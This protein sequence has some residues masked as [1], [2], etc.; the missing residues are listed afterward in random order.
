MKTIVLVNRRITVR[1]VAE[2]LNISIGSCHSIFIN[3]L[4]MTRAAAWPRNSYQNCSILTKNS[5]ADS[6]RGHP[7]LLQRLI[8]G[9]ESWVCGYDVQI[10][11][12]SFQSKLPHE[13]RSKKALQIRSNLTVFLTVFFVC[14]VV[15]RQF[16]PQGRMVKLCANCSK[17]S[18]RNARICGRTKIGF[19]TMITPLLTHRCLCAT[20]SAS[21]IGKT[22]AQ[23][24]NIWWGLL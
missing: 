5:I 2:D 22:L 18:A 10:K 15:V 21:T 7:N 24:Y 4:G 12:Q 1:E 9:D 16:W 14:R 6:V 23:V 17:Q 8:T 3:D 13:P 11:A 19:G 20:R